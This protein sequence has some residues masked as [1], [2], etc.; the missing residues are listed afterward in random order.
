MS[1]RIHVGDA[2]EVLRGM[3]AESVQCCV[4]SPPYWGLR[5]YR[6]DSGMIGLERTFDGHLAALVAVF[7]EVRRVLRPDGTCWLNYG[8]AYAGSWGAQSRNGAVGGMS[9]GQIR[10]HPKP[11]T[12]TGSLSRTP[13]LKPKDL[14]MMPSEVARHLRMPSLRCRGCGE[15]AH[16]SK[17]GRWP[18]GRRICPGCLESPG[19]AVETAG[20]WVR[21]PIVWHKR[22]PMPE[23]VTDRPTSAHEMV[24][25]LTKS[26]AALFW[27]HRDGHAQRTRPEPDYEWHNRRD[28]AVTAVEPDGC[29]DTQFTD[30][31][32]GKRKRL[33]VR[34]NL[35]RGHDYFYDAEA[36]RV[37]GP[38]SRPHGKKAAHNADRNDNGRAEFGEPKPAHANLRNVWSIPTFSFSA[39]H[40][41]TFPP[42]LV[43]P[44]IKA[45]TSERG[46][47]AK[48]GAPWRRVVSKKLVKGTNSYPTPPR[49]IEG[50]DQSTNRS[51][52]G[53]LGGGAHYD[54]ETTGWEPTCGCGAENRPCVCLDPFAGAGTVGLVADRLQRDAIL[55][56]ISPEYAEMARQRIREDG[57]ELLHSLNAVEIDQSL[58]P[59]EPAPLE[60]L[61]QLVLEHR[62]AVGP[63]GD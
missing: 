9:D 22:N 57:P 39:A 59:V 15:V 46:A 17:W 28:G 60:R 5:S 1:V 10:A 24:Y 3:P 18:D 52:D 62:H 21:S 25:L 36:V 44:C 4:S 56:E 27:T 58:R 20:W 41:A 40:F 2:L 53:H 43:E 63:A 54:V 55:I 38:G 47:C 26:G 32:D 51:R 11:G 61:P 34:A 16:E 14:I 29:R 33:W 7:R 42:A 12:N 35:W 31:Q 45:G 19:E 50:N 23:S 37:V 30:P 8:D 48:C 6:G 49:G 13:G